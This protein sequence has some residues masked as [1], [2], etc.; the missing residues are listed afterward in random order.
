MLMWELW[1]E[2][3][4]W[5]HLPASFFGNALAA[6]LEHGDRP[7]F[8]EMCE[9]RF[10]ELAEICWCTAEEDRPPFDAVVVTLE[11]IVPCPD[12]ANGTSVINAHEAQ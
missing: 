4:P 6:A 3:R 11:T 9:S 2:T 1:S 10:R 5:C 7:T 8:T 12:A